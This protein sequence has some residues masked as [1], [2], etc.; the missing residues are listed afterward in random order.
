MFGTFGDTSKA[1][2]E[3]GLWKR[4]TVAVQCTD[5]KEEKGELRTWVGA[6]P[7]VVIKE[8]TITANDRFALDP[9]GLYLFSSAKPEMMT[10]SI[11]VRTVRVQ[12]S[13]ATDA[14]V[15]ANRARDKSVGEILLLPAYI[16]KTELILLLEKVSERQFRMVVIQTDPYTGLRHHSGTPLIQMPKF[17]YRTCLV[18]NAISSKNVVDDVFWLAVYNMAIHNHPGDVDRFYDILIPFLTDKPLESTLVEA[19]VAAG[20]IPSLSESSSSELSEGSPRDASI[21][22]LFEQCGS[23]RA[24]QISKTAYVKTVM[25][26]F[27]YILCR[28]GLTEYLANQA[29]L[30]LYAELI[31]MMENDLRY[32]LPSDSDVKICELAV[33]EFSRYAVTVTD[34]LESSNK[35]S[36]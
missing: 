14:D 30:A 4:V 7:A 17:H 3:Q 15:K 23:W 24:P 35:D 16:E 31:T 25:E 18:L 29:H 33:R 36:K 6:E 21:K 9:D 5:K 19:E 12:M 2:V 28:R 20:N 8:D 10:A 11:A 26:A 27:H 34:F 13:V 1:R 32:I 22:K